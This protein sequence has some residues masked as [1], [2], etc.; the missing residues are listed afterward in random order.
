MKKVVL[1]LFVFI[2]L[3]QAEVKDKFK[4]SLGVMK[5]VNFETEMQVAPKH[6]PVGVRINTKDQLR[7]KNDTS[8]FRL[9]GYYRFNETHSIDF[10]YFSVNSD[11]F[12]DLG[13]I[14][15][16][17]NEITGNIYS[18]FDMDIYKINYAYSFYHND[19][20]E[21]ALTVGLHI[22][23]VKLGI[24]AYGIINGQPNSSYK[25]DTSVTVPLPVV[26]FKGE[27]RI[28]KKLFVSYKTD[29]LYLEFDDYKGA[30]V[31]SALNFE[32]RFV[33]NF[34]MGV[35]Y[36]VN[37]IRVEANGDNARADVLNTLSGA[38]LYFSYI[39]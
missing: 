17:D 30:L 27:Y 28:N 38:V 5:V 16:N 8:V 10:S 18:Y 39:Y 20:V 4:I 19:K 13:N 35:G 3:A 37:K 9:D 32:Y 21:L 29:Y 6:A 33:D 31:T 22:T 2:T 1:L 23:A 36:N 12:I 24:A 34:G 11:G 7:M 25:S 26:G 14:E 15:F